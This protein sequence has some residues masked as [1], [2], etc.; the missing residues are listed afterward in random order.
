MIRQ[1]PLRA[2]IRRRQEVSV[3]TIS[4]EMAAANQLFEAEVIA[5]GQFEALSRIYTGA[6]VLPPGSPMITGRKGIQEFWEQAVAALGVKSAKLTTIE[7]EVIGDTAFEIGQAD[8]GTAG[9]AIT[10]KYV[11]IWKREIG[12]WKWQV[13]IWNAA[14]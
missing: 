6:R 8:L 4:P 10:V 12:A 3:S 9:A 11:V 2:Y 1:R 5:K 7:I 13:D 14:S